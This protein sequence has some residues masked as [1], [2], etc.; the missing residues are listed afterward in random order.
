MGAAAFAA[1][2]VLVGCAAVPGT[3]VG[4]PTCSAGCAAPD[5]AE[6]RSVLAGPATV[7]VI[8]D[9]TGNDG[10]EWVALWA[11]KLGGAHRVVLHQWIQNRYKTPELVAGG[12]GPEIQIW[13]AGQPGAP[14]N[15]AVEHLDTVEPQRPDLV[16]ISAGH[17]NTSDDIGAQLDQLQGA[18]DGRWGP[19]PV[20]L[21]LQNR[22][23]GPHE[24]R[25]DATRSA[26]S[27]WATRQEVP[28]IDVA[29]ALT[30]PDR[31][32]RDDVHPNEAGSKS[33]AD[34]VA[35]ALR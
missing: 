30:D 6:A 27:A 24:Q 10:D 25:Q 12:H 3:P 9:S 8:G 22:G 11:A 21:I 31:Q 2:T 28:V 35:N 26:A 32:M 13:N 23:R 4:A 15:W 5:L 17:N 18:I 29:P 16:I 34:A 20:V 7:S 1:L 33:W 19:T 14:A